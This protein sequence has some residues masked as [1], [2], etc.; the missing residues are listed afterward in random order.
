MKNWKPLPECFH[1][2]EYYGADP[3]Y[4][5]LRNLRYDEVV[6]SLQDAEVVSELIQVGENTHR[7]PE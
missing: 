2:N 1:G 3:T 4:I 6:L 5:R 7:A